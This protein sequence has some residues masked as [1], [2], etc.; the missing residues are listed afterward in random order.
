LPNKLK[1]LHASFKTSF[2]TALNTQ[3]VDNY[4]EYFASMGVPS[5]TKLG[6]VFDIVHAFPFINTNH[7]GFT[8]DVLRNSYSS[9]L[10]SLIDINHDK[11]YIVGSIVK[12][13]LIE[14]ENKPLGIR[15]LAIMDKD[16]LR[17]WSIEDLTNEDWSMECKFANYLYAIGNKIVSPSEFPEIDERYNDIAEG[18]PVYDAIGN[19][20]GLLMGGTDKVNFHRCGLI[21]TGRGADQLAETHLQVAHEKGG[22]ELDTFTQEQL[23]QKL[24]E[25]KEL[26]A[27][28]YATKIDEAK[29]TTASEKDVEWQ[30]KYDELRASFDEMKSRAEVAEGTLGEIKAQELVAKRKQCLAEANYPDGMLE[31]KASFIASAS[32]EEF[33]AFVGEFKELSASFKPATTVV[34]SDKQTK[35][36]VASVVVTDSDDGKDVDQIDLGL[37]I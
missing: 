12:A 25:Q 18:Q 8:S 22:N 30:T 11:N 4:V 20:V 3:A 15:L 23:D 2:T 32:D 35:T 37:L 6:V 33:E 14:E 24:S 34:A 27:S 29:S 13:E 17:E 9:F 7:H 36:V 21:I 1:E 26:L 19:R 31:K 5:E 10:G 28:E 16:I